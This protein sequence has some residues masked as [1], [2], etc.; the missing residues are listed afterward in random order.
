MRSITKMVEWLYYIDTSITASLSKI[1]ISKSIYQPQRRRVTKRYRIRNT[2][3]IRYPTRA[4]I[5]I[6]I[7]LCLEPD[8]QSISNK[9]FETALDSK[10][11]THF[12]PRLTIWGITGNWNFKFPR[13]RNFKTISSTRHLVTKCNIQT[14]RIRSS[15]ER[16][17]KAQNKKVEKLRCSPKKVWKLENGKS[18]T[19]RHRNRVRVPIPCQS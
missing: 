18:N 17:W 19:S 12:I 6:H 9:T 7:K 15:K 11:P 1:W 14:F 8:K 5:W 10:V 3:T 16:P 2:A 13:H 4:L